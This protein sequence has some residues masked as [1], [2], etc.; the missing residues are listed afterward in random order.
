MTASAGAA[1]SC[2][3]TSRGRLC[4]TSPRG[5]V[6]RH[7]FQ[8]KIANDERDFFVYTPP[9]YDSEAQGNPIRCC[10]CTTWLV[11][12][13]KRLARRRGRQRDP[14]HPDQPGQSRAD[15]RR[16]AT[17][18]MELLPVLRISTARTC[19]RPYTRILLEELIPQVEK[20]YNVSTEPAGRAMAGLSMGGAESMHTGL[21]HL[22]TFAWLGSFSGAYNTLCRS[23]ARRRI[24]LPVSD[25]ARPRS[26]RWCSMSPTSPGPSPSLD[27]SANSNYRLLVDHPRHR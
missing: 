6:S 27:G 1:C 23:L 26:R 14:R 7:V 15:G 9:N 16:Y 2:P 17:S 4:P 19:C 10:T 13:H 3:A 25:S 12:R 20:Q 21:N 22:E 5:V 11:Q 24:L 18:P 8:S